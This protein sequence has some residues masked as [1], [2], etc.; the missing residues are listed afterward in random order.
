MVFQNV[1]KSSLIFQI[2][3]YLCAPLA[4]ICSIGL[5]SFKKKE[6]AIKYLSVNKPC[7]IV[8]IST[9]LITFGMLFGLSEVNNLFVQFLNK[10]GFEIVEATLPEKSFLSVSLIIIFVCVIPAVFEEIAF[11][12]IILNGLTNG[13]KVFA[14]LLSGALFSLFHMSPEQTIYQFIVGV[15]YS[16]IILQGGNYLLTVASHLF[17]NL[18]IVLNYYFFNLVFEGEVKI[19]ITVLG[20]LSLIVGLIMTLRVKTTYEKLENKRNI[21][22]GIPI[23]IIVCAFMWIISLVG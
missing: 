4:V 22:S 6:N 15:L 18:F 14:I 8:I 19:I 3:S 21:I 17:N 20:L 23:G 7:K 16:I 5:L 2:F 1:D 12:G 11:S 9:I 13:G 10:I